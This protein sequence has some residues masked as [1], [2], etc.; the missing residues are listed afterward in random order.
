MRVQ[1]QKVISHVPQRTVQFGQP[2]GVGGRGET[3][4]LGG[5]V[6]WWGVEKEAGLLPRMRLLGSFR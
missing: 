2:F 1:R 4:K 3:N 6:R 5:D